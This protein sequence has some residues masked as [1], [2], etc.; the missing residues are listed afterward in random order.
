MFSMIFKSPIGC[1]NIVLDIR[2][3]VYVYLIF[4]ET[5]KTSPTR[6]ESDVALHEP[7]LELSDEDQ[8]EYDFGHTIDQFQF[9]YVKE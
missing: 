2:L 1:L 3:Y 7:G 5:S 4:T 6:T 9:D 8:T